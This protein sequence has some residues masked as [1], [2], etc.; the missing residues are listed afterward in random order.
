MKLMRQILKLFSPQVES[1]AEQLLQEISIAMRHKSGR[2]G[3][4]RYREA[5]GLKINVGCGPYPK[6]GFLNLDYSKTADLRLDLRQPI[7]LPDGCSSLIF[8]EHFVEHLLYPDGAEAFFHDCYRLLEPG[9]EVLVS[10]P[11]T[12]WPLMQYASGGREWL[13]ACE[14]NKWHP[15]ECET[16]M[17][18][19]NYHFRQRESGQPDWHFETHRFAY[20]AETVAKHLRS[21]GFEEALEREPDPQ[22]DSPHRLVG[23]LFMR[24]VKPA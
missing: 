4:S 19:I 2:R 24:G 16:F 9:G 5:R 10:V 20:D 1:S 22:L 23:G 3:A 7:P 21:V 11:D 6:E 14:E 18:H 13:T 17:E 15:A 12:K 8:S